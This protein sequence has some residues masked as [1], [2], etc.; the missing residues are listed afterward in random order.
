MQSAEQTIVSESFWQRVWKW[1]RAVFDTRMRAMTPHELD[2]SD[3]LSS[4][5]SLIESLQK[6]VR[7]LCREREELQGKVLTGERMIIDLG[8]YIARLRTLRD[9]ELTVDAKRYAVHR[10][11]LDE[12]G[13]TKK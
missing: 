3:R 7:D 2:L 11:W 5:E 1:F 10:A 13:I 4:A 9:A 6:Q 12:Y 8:D